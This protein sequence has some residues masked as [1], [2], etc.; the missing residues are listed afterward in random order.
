M[1]CSFFMAATSYKK[2]LEESPIE[3][4]ISLRPVDEV[5]FPA[6]I[7]DVGDSVDPLGFV[8]ASH[9]MVNESNIPK[10]GMN[11]LLP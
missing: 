10:K 11:M 4:S 1:V 8:R 7:I 9:N 2:A 3:T 5:P 6:I